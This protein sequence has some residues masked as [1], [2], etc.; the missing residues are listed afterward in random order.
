MLKGWGIMIRTEY[1]NLKTL[2]AIAYRLKLKNRDAGIVIMKKGYNQPGL[3]YIDKREARPIIQPNINTEEF[4]EESFIEAIEL[5]IGMPYAKR[6]PVAYPLESISEAADAVELTDNAE[7][8]NIEDLNIINSK[9][10]EAILAA[11][12]DKKGSL[13]Y[14]LLNRDFIKFAV[15][16]SM[17]SK[18]VEAKESTEDIL[19]YIVKQRLKTVTNNENLN[20]RMVNGIIELLD[21]V[22]RQYVFKELKDEIRKLQ[23]R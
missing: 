19:L 6:K 2:E 15:K 9:E 3:A 20:D 18:I 4:P 17:V 23:A 12:T 11:Y 21:E 7:E 22:S 16:S 5:T 1:V 13:S 14:Q 10:Y 8:E